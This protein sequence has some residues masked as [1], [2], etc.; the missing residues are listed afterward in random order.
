MSSI[1]LTLNGQQSHLRAQYFPPIDISDGEY[2][3]GLIDFQTFNTI[4][5][6][7]ERNNKFHFEYVKQEPKKTNLDPPNNWF[8]TKKVIEIPTGTYELDQ[9]AEF[10]K[11]RMEFLNLEL[12]LVANKNTNK[13]ELYSSA[14][15]DFSAP[16]SIGSLLGFQPKRYDDKTMHVS[17]SIAQI[18]H[19]NIIRVECNIIRGSYINDKPAHTIHEF[20]LKVPPGYK[21][22]EVPKNVIYFPVTVKSISSVNIVC[23]DQE[24]RPINFQGE[25]VTVRLHIKKQNNN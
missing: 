17:E 23:V 1:T 3:C 11:K 24:H 19:V 18:F 8:V 12:D 13:C 25:T 4:P 6:V 20:S 2:V 14:T 10:L 15:I 9:I 22:I 21:I 5:N 7:D 16:N